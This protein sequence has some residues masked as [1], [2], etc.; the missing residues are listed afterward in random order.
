[1]K[2]LF[3]CA[4]AAAVYAPVLPVRAA[5][6]P[7]LDDALARIAQYAPQA[8][9]EQGAPGVSIAITDRTHTL[10]IITLGYAD[11]AAKAPVTEQ[12]RFPIGSITKSMTAISLL[13]LHDDGRFDPQQPVQAYLPWFRIDAKGKTI[14][15]HQLLSHT[16]GLPDDY[17]FAPGYG[18][19]VAALRETH[20]VFAPGTS[21]SYSNDGFE[22]LGAIVAKLDRKPWQDALAARVFTPLGMTSS[23][24]V[25]TPETLD[26]QTAIGYQYRD[27]DRVTPEQP[28]LAATYPGTFIDPA[29]S[30]ISTPAD[31]ARYVRFLLNRGVT[32]D[33]KRVISERSYA[34]LTTP[35]EMNGRLAGPAQPLLAEAPDIFKTYAYGLG[36]HH[37]GD[38]LVVGHTG[39]IS[40][41]TACMEANV[42]R[43]FGVVAMSNLIEAPLHPCAIVLYAMSVLRAQSLGQSLPPIPTEKDRASVANAA[44]FAGTFNGVDGSSLTFSAEG[45][46]LA[47][48][49]VT[50]YPRG[51]D[52]FW[53]DDPRFAIFGL[54][55]G[56]DRSGRVVEVR[57]GSQWFVSDAYHG[58]KGFDTP[59]KWNA[60]VGRYDAIPIFGTPATTRV[61]VVK[62]R[63]T[64]DGA[65]PLVPTKD[66][67]YDTVEGHVRFDMAAG[68]KM[69]RIWLDA[70]PLYRVDLP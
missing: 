1:M 70:T 15:A 16:A 33:G 44:E 55:F 40:G 42:S 48:N 66:G 4:L 41:Y 18:F 46:H 21:F 38:D 8:Q 28:A 5:P 52:L 49:G 56:R 3:A 9:R 2:R 32:D 31:M 60:L 67:G 69:Q 30:V 25:F 62:G 36:I 65:V 17:T 13:E 63:L 45:S 53:V 35:D 20:V 10:K 47:M 24:A 59:Q 54:Q 29:G 39:G 58:T 27:M 61:L 7:T 22:T 14:Y 64:L 43:G 19:D 23:S 34:L 50:L 37:E 51:G 68:G 57:S 6:A 26:D 11:I 12:T